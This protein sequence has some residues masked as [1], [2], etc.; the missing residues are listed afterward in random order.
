MIMAVKKKK[1]VKVK[2]TTDVTITVSKKGAEILYQAVQ[3]R[4]VDLEKVGSSLLKQKLGDAAQV[5]FT[6]IKD[7]QKI[8]AK[9]RGDVDAQSEE[10][11]AEFDELLTKAEE[12]AREKGDVSTSLLQ[13]KLG[14]GYARAAG[15]LEQLEAK[16]VVG[17]A[18]GAK[19]RVVIAQTPAAEVDATDVEEGSDEE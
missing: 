10:I 13:R 12:V 6:N 4:V 7:L 18:D 15:L 8:Q 17:P 11:A 1:E 3:D 9:L 16:G 2:K 19:P 5:I 14:I